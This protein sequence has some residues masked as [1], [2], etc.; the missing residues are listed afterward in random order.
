MLADHYSKDYKKQLE[1]S[2]K[3][4]LNSF[5]IDNSYYSS[6]RLNEIVTHKYRLLYEVLVRDEL[7]LKN[8]ILYSC[9]VL[10]LKHNYLES[11][12]GDLIKQ[13]NNVAHGKT[14]YRDEFIWPLP[15][16]FSS[17]YDSTTNLET[18]FYFMIN[19]V[20]HY[21]DL[22]PL[23]ELI[24][25]FNNIMIP[26]KEFINQLQEGSIDYHFSKDELLNGNDFMFTY[27]TIFYLFVHKME[28]ISIDEIV[29]I[30]RD[31]FLDTEINE[32]C[33]PILMNISILFSDSKDNLVNEKAK[34]NIKSAVKNNWFYWSNIKDALRYL[35]Y[36]KTKS[37]WFKEWILNDGHIICRK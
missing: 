33:G 16:F 37:T 31:E 25:F 3:N 27:E 24:V 2:L 8:R 13:R 15:P 7:S 34:E 26:T 35:D 28:N 30:V 4:M 11:F 23:D 29:N 18:I 10:N 5:Y 32:E 22:K 9:E 19:L 1:N 36:Y 21:F 12:I 14:I 20:Y 17:L 6:N